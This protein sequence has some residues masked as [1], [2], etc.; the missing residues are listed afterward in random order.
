MSDNES[1]LIHAVGHNY[2]AIQPTSTCQVDGTI[3]NEPPS[4]TAR[5]AGILLVFSSQFFFACMNIS[6][7]LLNKLEPPVHAFQVI[8]V[9]M[10]I[11]FICCEIYMVVM[12]IPDPII[13]PK[14]VRM[15]LVIRG[16]SGF[17]GLSGLYLSLQYLSVADAT[18][19]GF[20]KPLTTAVAGCILLKERFS[21]KQAVA[22]VCSLLGVVLVARPPFLFG[23]LSTAIPEGHFLPE[24]TPA[25]RLSGVAACMM[26]VL[27]ATA[28]Y[29]SIRAIGTRA[30]ALHIMTF[31]ALGSTIMASLGM[32]A[33]NISVVYP[34]SRSWTWI[35]LLLMNG[36][37]GFVAQALLTMGLQRETASRGAMGVYIEVLFA[38]I[39][40]R[41]I[42]GII[43]SL[44]SVIGAAI[45]MSCALYVVVS[46]HRSR[47]PDVFVHSNLTTS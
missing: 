14:G 7:K 6:V 15:L 16:I 30:H 41:L 29:T 5:N 33:F 26:H 19:L 27:G 42:F 40:E 10:G 4:F 35:L 46:G 34:T 9:R 20:L 1:P 38:V 18:V 11:T 21:I 45:I 13:G 24:S 22:G 12:G 8:V 32:V 2:G 25:Q 3:A 47:F 28:A 44:L 31:F 37:F 17:F 39:L 36:V 23:S 43:P